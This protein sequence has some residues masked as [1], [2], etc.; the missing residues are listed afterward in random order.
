MPEAA[1]LLELYLRYAEKEAACQA[2]HGVAAGAHL[3]P[4]ALTD[5]Y[6]DQRVS[7]AGG[8]VEAVDALLAGEEPLRLVTAGPGGGKTS[9]L[10]AAIGRGAARWERTG[11]PCPLPVRVA[12]TALARPD[13]E[14]AHALA[15]AVNGVLGLEGHVPEALFASPPWAGGRWLVMIDGLDEVADRAD[16]KKILSDLAGRVHN[17]A[18]NTHRFVVATRPLPPDELGFRGDV[19]R[20]ELL[21]FGAADLKSA[22]VKWFRAREQQDGFFAARARDPE[23][24]AGEFVAAV[25]RSGVDSLAYEPLF[26]A[27]LWQLYARDPAR[28]LPRGRS[29]IYRHFTDHLLADLTNRDASSYIEVRKYFSNYYHHDV[30]DRADD[31]VKNLGDIITRVAAERFHRRT[32]KD[33][34]ILDIVLRQPGAQ[35]PDGI[36]DYKYRH[37]EEF[38]HD[39]LCRS[40]LL[41]DEGGKLEFL[42]PTVEDYLAARYTA[43]DPAASKRE[44]RDIFGRWSHAGPRQPYKLW[45]PRRLNWSYVQF[46]VAEWEDRPELKKALR[47]L[48]RKG[49]L[50]GWLFIALMAEWSADLDSRAVKDAVVGC[51]ILIRARAAD[52]TDQWWAA[53]ALIELRPAWGIRE[54]EK[55]AFDDRLPSLDR[56]RAYRV[57]ASLQNPEEGLGANPEQAPLFAYSWTAESRSGDPRRKKTLAVGNRLSSLPLPVLVISLGFWLMVATIVVYP[58]MAGK[59]GTILAICGLL[60]VRSRRRSM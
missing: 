25:I 11:F 48:A 33:E 53:R 28:P 56:E 57:L 55:I 43:R 8:A 27:L 35:R 22:A 3:E 32:E 4:P 23:A 17:P 52:P 41:I 18:E 45:L 16:R 24:A 59:V 37:W 49:G 39:I 29:Q 54:L 15:T 9:L 44:F 1:E 21:P 14:I 36:P 30:A 58:R 7:T 2:L 46:L 5:I 40:G 51:T 20:L 38:L 50:P 42:H 13:A 19:P 10:R 12:A 6:V 31:T 26:A 47:R 60:W 34:D